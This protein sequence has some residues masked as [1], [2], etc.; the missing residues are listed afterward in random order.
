MGAWNN[1]STS[2][3][4]LRRARVVE[5]SGLGV[6]LHVP[7]VD[8]RSVDPWVVEIALAALNQE[9]LEVMV[10][11]GQTY[12]TGQLCSA[13]GPQRDGSRPVGT[14]PELPPP[15]TMISTSSGTVMIAIDPING[16]LK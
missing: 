10:Q 5:C 9:D 7:W 8:T 1:S 6:Q 2:I 4:P 3:E 12:T 14:H 11:I 13:D 15:Q 16:F